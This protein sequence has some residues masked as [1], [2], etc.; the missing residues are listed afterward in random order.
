M[1]SFLDFEECVKDS[2]KFRLCLDQSEAALSD[3]E[4]RV[5]KVMKLCSRMVEAGQAYNTASQLFLTGL[6]DFS[7]YHRKDSGIMN[8]LQQFSEGLQEMIH[9]HS[10]KKYS[11][12][13]TKHM[14][15]LYQMTG[16]FFRCLPQVKDTK[17]ELMRIK[18]DLETAIVKNAQVP[19]HKVIDAEQASHLL[20]AT[21]KC[22]QHFGLDY[23]LQVI[24]RWELTAKYQ[25]YFIMHNC[26]QLCGKSVM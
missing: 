22:Y 7:V 14:F 1:D 20:L 16:I 11:I 4:G 2:P 19:R 21:R 5:E 15:V 26:L 3:L 17:R 18:E 25:H 13:K 23:C 24:I 6:V 10:V 9:F 12:Y 8:C